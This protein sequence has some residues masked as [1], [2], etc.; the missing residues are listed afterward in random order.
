MH[1]HPRIDII[2]RFGYAVADVTF[3]QYE[4]LYQAADGHRFLPKNEKRCAPRF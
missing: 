1:M 3:H 4:A 2:P